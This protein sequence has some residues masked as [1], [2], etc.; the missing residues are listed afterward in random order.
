M[1]LIAKTFQQATKKGQLKEQQIMLRDY[2]IS[3]NFRKNIKMEHFFNWLKQQR[4]ITEPALY[5]EL[6]D[7]LNNNFEKH[8]DERVKNAKKMVRSLIDDDRVFAVI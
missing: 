7:G 6:N 2:I 5:W 8:L 1:Q 3:Y 4:G